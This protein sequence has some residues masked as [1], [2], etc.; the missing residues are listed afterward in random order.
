[1][2]LRFESMYVTICDGVA[3]SRSRS[4]GAVFYAYTSTLLLVDVTQKVESD[5]LA[6]SVISQTKSFEI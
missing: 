1:M 4:V 6:T 2:Y 5:S 3:R